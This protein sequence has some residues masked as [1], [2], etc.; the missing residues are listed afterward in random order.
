M[1][2]LYVSKLAPHLG[3]RRVHEVGRRL[4]D[5]GH[6]VTVLSAA[7]HRHQPREETVDGMRVLATRTAPAVLRRGDRVGF[8]A[9]RLPFYLAAPVK[10]AG[11]ADGFDIVVE[12]VTPLRSPFMGLVAKRAGVP[13]VLQVHSVF[14]TVRDWITTYGVLGAVGRASEYSLRKGRHVAAVYSD[15]LWTVESVR[16]DLPPDVITEWIPNGVDL[17]RFRPTAA[18]RP[19]G[20]QRLLAVGRLVSLKNYDTLIRALARVG[21][22][23]QLEIAGDGPQRNSLAELIH[24]LGVGDRVRLLGRIDDAELT[25]VYRRADVFVHPSKVEGMPLS[26]V[27]AM[28][29]GLPIV[30]S[31]IP[32]A[33]GVIDESYGWLAA[34]ADV[35]SWTAVLGE[36]ES[37]SPAELRGGGAAARLRCE[38]EFNWDVAAEHELELL[39][40]VVAGGAA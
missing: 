20:P 24:E 38:T 2:V 14:P 15:A 37:T 30:M 29:S 12:D 39:I 19:P 36:I 11:L 33:S 13:L 18:E 25:E 9:T 16:R 21:G 28:A 4:V 23:S 17:E 22:T 7:T 34:R 6:D 3:I 40:R 10:V 26:V 31:D 27:E 32:A 8:F 5:K 1:R 35:D